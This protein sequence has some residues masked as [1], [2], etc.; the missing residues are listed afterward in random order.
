MIVD[1]LYVLMLVA[2]AINVASAAYVI[3]AIRS[4]NAFKRDIAPSGAFR[5][6]VT[7]L[8]PVC[9]L[10]EALY[11]NLR[12][13][14]RQDYPDYQ[15]VFGVLDSDDPAIPTIERLIEDLPGVDIELVVD[16]SV[17]GGN[18]KVSNLNNMVRAAK[19]DVLVIA[20]SD[21]RVDETY[22]AA[23]VSPFAAADVGAVTCLYKGTPARRLPSV[24]ASMFI[25]EWF[26]PSVLV[27]RQTSRS[28]LLLR[29]HD[30]RA[31]QSPRRDRRLQSHF[32]LPGGRSR[33]RQAGQRSRLQGRA[34]RLCRREHRVRG[35]RSS[36]S[37]GMSCA[38]RGPCA[39][40]N[41]YGHAFSFIMY[42]IPLALIG[43]LFMWLTI[44]QVW[45]EIGLVAVAVAL[46][47]AMHIAVRR[48]LDLPKDHSLWLVPLRD[49]VSFGVWA[50]SLLSRHIEWR[51]KPFS[52]SRDGLLAAKKGPAL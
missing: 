2:V 8:K 26:L 15:I 41:R 13:F 35:S 47:A 46:R 12:S 10:D 22:L 19:H 18:L 40:S 7:V 33:T 3:L 49:M 52:V 45:F 27:E 1:V 24:L 4:V 21:M 34:L 23:V 31:A 32:E 51:G 9:G 5:P 11:E 43:A 6:P 17:I 14:C 36:A 25:N 28:P 30:G 44:D 42:G 16:N 20:D 50:T 39:R 29:R 48:K 38:G 37:S